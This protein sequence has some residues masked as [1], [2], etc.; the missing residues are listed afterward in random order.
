MDFEAITIADNGT[1]YL[2][3][4]VGTSKLY[5]IAPGEVDGNSS[6]AVN[7]TYIGNTGLSAGT[8]DDEITALQFIDGRLYGIGRNT[9]KVWE[10][11]TSDGSVTQAGTLNVAGSFQT[12]GMTQAAN[13]IVYLTKTLSSNS[14]IW[15]FSSFP[16]GSLIKVATIT[17]SGALK[18]ISAHPDGDLYTADSSHWYRVDPVTGAYSTVMSTSADIEGLDFY[19]HGERKKSYETMYYIDNVASGDGIS[20]I[21]KVELDYDGG[22]AN[23][24][25]VTEIPFDLGHIAVTLNGTRIYATQD[26][27]PYHLGY[28]DLTT[29]T[30]TDVGQITEGG[31]A[32][33]G[34]C[35]A[36]FSPNG[37]LY[38][39]SGSTDKVYIIDTETA[40]ATSLGKISVSG[41]DLDIAGADL[42]F[43]ADGVLYV[44]T[45]ADTGRLYRITGTA[46]N[47]Q[48]T[49]VGSSSVSTKTTGLAITDA[50][51][52]NFVYS[53]QNADAMVVVDRTTGTQLYSLS[54]YYNGSAWDAGTGD[55]S[56]GC[57]SPEPFY[58]EIVDFV[59]L[60]QAP[61]DEYNESAM[62]LAV[63]AG[64]W[65][66]GDFY[67]TSGMSENDTV[68]RD[69]ESSDTNQPEDWDRHGGSK[70]GGSTPAKCNKATVVINEVMFNPSGS[71]EG[72]E[73]VE[74]YNPGPNS[75][76]LSGWTLTNKWGTVLA[77]LPAWTMPSDSY[78]R[79]VFGSGTNDSSFG[80]ED[81]D[82]YD[83]A[84]YYAGV[85]YSGGNPVLL[86]NNDDEL[87]LHTGTPSLWNII[88]FMNWHDSSIGTYLGGIAHLRAWLA[89]IWDW[90]DY[91]NIHTNP[92][93]DGESIGRDK[94]STDTN[95]PADWD[96]HGGKDAA[97]DTPGARNIPEFGQIAVPVM[98]VLAVF[99]VFRRRRK[100]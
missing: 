50:G 47:L 82:G 56:T 37:T 45:R 76:N 12:Y 23:L 36:A 5:S 70:A 49:E 46:G 100:R 29:D 43:S 73:W 3:N 72:N 66:R 40:K 54:M 74:L 95:Q 8:A 88:D 58:D 92:V 89:G 20:R 34:L 84:T 21:T 33:A 87:A 52:G 91:F 27:S 59:S 77:T 16:N 2:M 90:G 28:Y 96:D 61:A 1:L 67:N 83:D 51:R 4:N 17:G 14:E 69:W 55:M 57:V 62:G 22:R 31:S 86:R 25:Y 38:A 75:V 53:D 9:K 6:T 79:I 32:V 30:F 10:I 42:A 48:G 80:D 98:A 41:G 26:Q 35:Q 60:R 63:D 24:T 18:G 65:E 81:G 85:P 7:A 19:F 68:G 15:K 39:A 93:S 44:A 99:A 11:D 64:I 71:D 78:L 13:G 97:I 94:D